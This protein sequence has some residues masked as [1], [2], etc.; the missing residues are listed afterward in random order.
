VLI[1]LLPSKVIAKLDREKLEKV[2]KAYCNYICRDDTYT[3]CYRW[4]VAQI[5]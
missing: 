4:E 2:I 1:V 5:H 3:I